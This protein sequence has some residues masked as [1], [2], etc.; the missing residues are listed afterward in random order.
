VTYRMALAWAVGQGVEESDARWLL[1]EVARVSMT[2]YLIL[3]DTTME[4]TQVARFEEMIRRRAK[5]EP[6]QH[7]LGFWGFGDLT[8]KTDGRALIPRPET[9]LLVEEALRLLPEEQGM[10]IADVGCGTGCIGLSMKNA[11][12]RDKVTLLDISPE[13][14]E[15]AA[16]NADLLRLTVE[17]LPADMRETLPGGPYDMICSNPPYIPRE[18]CEA[19]D[20]EVRYFDPML[21]LDGGEDGL[22]FYRALADRTGDS[23]KS[24][25]FVVLE[26]GIGQAEDVKKIFAPVADVVDL[27]KDLAGIDRVLSLR[28]R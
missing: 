18:D 5:G 26:L 23:L 2:Q 13:A 6:V 20:P 19:L 15:L 27:K 25:G 1:Q 12:L 17:I 11:R 16:E 3:K 9:E 21:A 24:G 10:R 14:R 7:V 8:L 22:D 4:P 28:K